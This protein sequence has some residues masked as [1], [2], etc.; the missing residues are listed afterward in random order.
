MASKQRTQGSVDIKDTDI[1][2]PQSVA[3]IRLVD[4]N[5]AAE[6]E[7]R[8]GLVLRNG[9]DLQLWMY[10]ALQPNIHVVDHVFGDQ[11]SALGKLTAG[12]PNRARSDGWGYETHHRRRR[13]RR[14]GRV[15]RG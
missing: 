14:G 9:S 13:R 15:R 5:L 6:D 3:D 10:L 2:L 8:I 12:Q 1:A 11:M 7:L 4:R